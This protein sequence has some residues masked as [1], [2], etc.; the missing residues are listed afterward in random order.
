MPTTSIS[1]ANFPH[2]TAPSFDVVGLSMFYGKP[3]PDEER[4]AVLNR[5]Y[6]MGE[7]NWDTADLYGDNEILIGNWFKRTGKRDEVRRTQPGQ[8]RDGIW[9]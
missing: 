6:E 1:V 9:A 8:I 2:V 5:A 7:L 4:F 3:Y